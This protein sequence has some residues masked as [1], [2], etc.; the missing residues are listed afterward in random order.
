MS[1]Q[2]GVT[3]TIDDNT[4]ISQLQQLME[5]AGNI[6]PALESIVEEV[7]MI[8]TAKR[9]EDEE[10]PEG[11][12]WMPL[13][14]STIKH[15]K[16]NSDKIL[17]LEGFLRAS[18]HGEISDTGLEFG[19]DKIQAATHQFGRQLGLTGGGRSLGTGEASANGEEARGEIPARP[20][21][22]FSDADKVEILD[23]LRFFLSGAK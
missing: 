9:F 22:G 10:S 4:V 18:F 6:R 8:S 1:A 11:I 7:L 5:R 20:F 19:T 21:L 15:K 3:I 17:T 2:T 14:P 12:A 13:L 16:K 23:I